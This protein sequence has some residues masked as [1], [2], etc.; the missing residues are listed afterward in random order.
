MPWMSK[1]EGQLLVRFLEP[2]PP[3]NS[4]GNLKTS[5]VCF[6]S[7]EMKNL[8]QVMDTLE[9]I[10]TGGWQE[11]DEGSRKRYQ[12]TLI[13]LGLIIIGEG[14]PVISSYGQALVQLAE[15]NEYTSDQLVDS[16]DRQPAFKYE[17]LILR[18]LI[19]IILNQP[20]GF[21]KAQGY[22]I[23]KLFCMQEFVNSIPEKRLNDILSDVDRLLFLQIIFSSRHEI[24]RYFDLSEQEQNDAYNVWDR[25]KKAPDFPSNEPS[26]F[27]Q[28]M[29]FYYVRPIKQTIQADIRFRVQAALRAYVDLR[30]ML[31]ET[32]PTVNANLEV[33]RLN[34][35]AEKNKNEYLLDDPGEKA[36]I[37]KSNQLII[38]G[39]PGSGKSSF[40]RN[41]IGVDDN[42]DVKIITFHPD[43]SY[44]DLVGAYK[45]VPVYEASESIVKASG[46]IFTLGIPRITYEFLAGPLINR[47]LYAV[48]NPNINVFLIV[49][50]INRTNCNTVFG[51]FFQLLDRDEKGNSCY[52]ITAMPEL[53]EFLQNHSES[54]DIKFPS[55]L[56]IWGTMNSADQ[57]VFPLDSAFRRRW[58]FI[59]MGYKTKCRYPADDAKIKY[60]GYQYSWE[61]FRGKINE[62]LT[63]LQVHEDKLI[64]PYFLTL[65][66]MVNPDK[67]MN[68]LFLYLWED[69]LRFQRKELMDF[70]SF[71]DLM[72]SWREGNGSPLNINFNEDR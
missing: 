22:A 61:K 29:A 51:D 53:S 15:H 10:S 46:E 25:L 34:N 41:L 1:D 71:A 38:C 66:E 67:V 13:N 11:L 44:T 39:C 40:I 3:R 12:N 47:Y 14:D 56:Y 8:K 18:N 63:S 9:T 19:D 32:F 69:V 20:K 27:L 30:K 43:F 68:K 26:D 60:G 62:K 6:Y 36:N 55:N 42:A 64:G 28:C 57:G 48:K 49:E 50:E 5:Y 72:D 23:E 33:R 65:E 16:V 7:S 35:M 37:E 54:P 45:P 2:L 17:K 70:D 52:N 31:N 4:H 24:R 58:E 59:Y 21:E